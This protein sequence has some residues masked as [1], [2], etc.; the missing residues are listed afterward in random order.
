MMKQSA[1]ILTN[2]FHVLIQSNSRMPA[3]VPMPS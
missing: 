1:K 3:L 2:A